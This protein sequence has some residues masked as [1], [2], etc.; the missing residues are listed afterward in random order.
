MHPVIASVL[1]ALAALADAAQAD[2]VPA[3]ATVALVAARDVL[4]AMG[5]E[6]KP[7]GYEDALAGVE[8]ALTALGYEDADED[9]PAPA[10]DPPPADKTAT[11]PGR[12]RVRKSDGAVHLP[13]LVRAVGD[14]GLAVLSTDDEDSYGDIV[15][16]KTLRLERF[17]TNPVLL[18]G[19]SHACPI[20]TWADVAI[21]ATDKAAAL[22]G[23]PMFDD[24]ADSLDTTAK[25]VS[26]KWKSKQLRGVSIGFRPEWRT[27]VSRGS[28]PKD[29][30]AFKE[31]SWGLFFEGAELLEA[32]IVAVPANPNAVG[33]AATP[34]RTRKP[35]EARVPP[36]KDPGAGWWT[37]A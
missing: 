9:E 16:V 15:D 32:S 30:W 11:I 12:F 10:E 29:H 4:A 17:A 23:R 31:G 27:S 14:D 25:L 22:V 35:A 2:D 7:E 6:D 36:A 26:S 33:K 20:G 1:S 24:A 37:G 21:Q 5:D 34:R 19:H 18:W 13:M 8:A 3:C 28:L